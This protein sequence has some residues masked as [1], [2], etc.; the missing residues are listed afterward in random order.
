MKNEWAKNESS[1]NPYKPNQVIDVKFTSGQQ[2]NC[3]QAC[4]HDFSVD[5]EDVILYSRIS[6]K[7]EIKR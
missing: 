7:K 1:I 4:Y 5:A 3:I 6:A 2:H